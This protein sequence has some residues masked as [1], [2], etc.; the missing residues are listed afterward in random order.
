MKSW[1]G[2]SIKYEKRFDMV[3]VDR[4]PSIRTDTAIVV[5]A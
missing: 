1:R 5:R 2:C 3:G 4:K